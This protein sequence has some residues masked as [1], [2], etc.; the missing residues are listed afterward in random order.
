MNSFQIIPAI[1][2]LDGKVVRLYRGDYDR[3]TVY[4]DSTGDVISSFIE[5]GAKLIHLVDLNAART[6][7][8]T[9]NMEALDEA[10]QA[11]GSIA[12]LELGGGIRNM[13]DLRSVFDS[14]IH[15]AILGS[16]AVRSPEFLAE[17]IH[18]YGPKKI[19]VGV[20]AR[21]GRVKTDGWE[22]DGGVTV[23]D[24]LKRLEEM[25]VGEVIFTDIVT[26]G[27]LSGPPVESLQEVL[28]ATSMRV[29]ASGG[30][31]SLDDIRTLLSM[32]PRRPSG[33]ITGRAVYEGK[34]DVKE[35]VELTLV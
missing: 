7:D 34:L 23:V 8:R 22:V 35:A 30:I 33:A 15:R 24:F 16:A 9:I 17:A 21:D 28:S 13:D 18:E 6:G 12:K 32:E 27:T 31:S 2:L 20:D 1:D 5:A 10:V 29:I 26:D 4:G 11:A 3:V 25:E 19:I 14:G